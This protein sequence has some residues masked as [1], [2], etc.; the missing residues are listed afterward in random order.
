MGY[1]KKNNISVYT[2]KENLARRQEL[3]DRITKSD[4]YMPDSILHDDL[5]MGMLEFVKSNLQV[6][7]DGN[8]IPIIP[9]ILTVQRW[10]EISSNWAF[11]DDDGN[12]KVPFIGVVR[13]PDVQPGTNPITQRTI[14]DRRQ[15][16][17]ASVQT[18]NGT[19]IGADVYKMPQPVA[20][21]IG[22]EVTIVCQ[23]FRDLNRFNKRVLQKFS[24]RQAY[25]TVKGHYVPIILDRI[26]DNSPIEALEGR[27]F[28]LQTYEF[29][30]LGFLI[31]SEEFEVKPAVNRLLLLNEF[32]QTKNFSTKTISRSIEVKNTT[33]IS[34]GLTTVFSVGEMI[35]FLFFVSVN[36]LI[37]QRNIDYYWIGQTSRI[38]FS[39][40]PVTGSQIMVSYY[41]GR[42]N[43]FQDA[44]GNL[45]FLEHENF[46]Y[47]G[48][49]LTFTTANPINNVLYVEINGL[50]DEE[51]VGFTVNHTNKVT[52]LGTPIV[53][54]RVGI[55]YLR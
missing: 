50:V 52:L 24:S 7:S 47:D 1:P 15:F 11:T 38:V 26:S 4:P 10:G 44:Y 30:M 31:D 20:I 17:Y 55:S 16:Y 18:W 32:L 36:G 29:T 22:F 35:G 39:T 27:R 49:S 46:V 14:P 21:D 6:I 25:T 51:G 34:D 19:Q 5:D 42:S 43:V 33:F 37:Q 40:P 41:A 3:L 23:K 53:G 2:Q 45:L 12:I 13:R 28:Y 9:K 8:Q 48:S 54:S